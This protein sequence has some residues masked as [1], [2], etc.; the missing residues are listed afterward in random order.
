MKNSVLPKRAPRKGA[1]GCVCAMLAVCSARADWIATG[2]FN[3]TD[4]LY[5]L[6]AFTGTLV[7][8]VREADVQ[9]YDTTT[10]A[11]LASGATDSSGSFSIAVADAAQRNVGVRVLSSNVQVASLNFSVVDD[12]NSD[13]IY[14][15]HDATVDQAAHLPEANVNFGSMTMPEAIGAVASTDWSS[16]IFNVYDMGVLLA[17]WI[18]NADGARPTVFYTILWNPT[19]GRTGSSYNSSTNRLSLSDDDGYDDSNILHEIGHYI[20]DEYGR[21][22]NT[23]GTH[24][25]GDN[26]QDPRLAYSEGFATFV[27]SA[28]LN[29]AGRPRPDIYSDRDSFGVSGGGGFAYTFEAATVG[30]ATNE[31]AVTAALYDLIDTSATLDGNPGTDDDPIGSQQA[32]VWSVVE[33]MRVI[34]PAA[35]SL[36]DF[37]DIWFSLGLGS[38]AELATVFTAHNI[39]FAPDA[40]EPNDTPSTATPLTVGGAYQRNS[41]YR[42]GAQAAGD[43]DW[44]KFTAT[45]GTCY[46]IEVNGAGNTIFGRPDPEMWLI[47]PTLSTVLAYNDDPYDATLNT[48]ASSTAQD[49]SETVPV[50][51]WQAPSSGVHYLYVRHASQERNL[52]GR[53]GTYQIRV[54]SLA[55]P[56]PTITSVSE[57]RMLQGQSYQ[58]L[59]VG[60]NFTRGATVSTGNAGVTVSEVNWIAPTALVATLTPSAGVADGSY[61][62]SVSN[63]G[64]GS[65][66][67]TG[68][69]EVNA[70]AVPP[71]MMTELN[72]SSGLVEVKNLGT[73]S[74]TLTGWKIQSLRPST[75]TQ[76]FTFPAFSLAAG[77]T[78]VVHESAGTNTSTDLFDLTNSF[79]WPWVNGTSG[80]VSL[81]DDG[82]RNVDY[83]RVVSSPVTEHSLPQG[84]GGAWMAPQFQSPATGFTVARSETTALYRTP[85]GL[86]RAN[87]TMPAT[88]SGRTNNVDPWEDNDLARRAPLFGRVALLSGLRISARP[89]GTDS[90]WFGFIVNPGD[91]VVF[92]AAFTNSAGNLDMQ[93]YAPGEETTPLLSASST[94]DNETITLSPAQSTATGG[95]IYR[96]RVF[97]VSGAV[98]TY[99][100]S[101]GPVVTIAATDATAS[102]SNPSDTGQ[103]TITRSGSLS[104]ALVTRFAVGGS[105]TNGVDYTSIGNTLTIPASA[106]SATIPISAIADNLAEG[107]EGV[108]LT[109]VADPAYSIGAASNATVNIADKPIDAWR[110][111]NFGGNPA[112]SGDEADADGDGSLNLL[113]YGLGMNPN[114]PGV[115]GLP[116]LGTETELGT[117]YLTLTYLK[118]TSKSDIVYQVQSS[119]ALPGWTNLGDVL[120]GSTNGI[121]TRKARVAIGSTPKFMRLKIS[122]P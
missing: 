83:L 75:T 3:Y 31:Q 28:V 79:N 30:G 33:Q 109:L 11:V 67:S 88:A 121:E 86:S 46:A 85:F 119:V 58:V 13:A 55:T 15:Y 68:A 19:N 102:E 117:S 94:S 65:A 20:E 110:F 60:T 42:T 72:L 61:S 114:V 24:F 12:K 5:D 95:G 49:M 103:F 99:T 2:Q 34:S 100:L 37:W 22:R 116:V 16:Q 62:L 39:D 6:S 97:G 66:T 48:Q 113:E 59:V 92:N 106:A 93:L 63:P 17:D 23:G 112:N 43:E 82:G 32:A 27:S 38:A 98:N 52:L 107:T 111:A 47:D 73:V 36:E 45:A 10:L 44:F 122:R 115:A 29:Y 64:G 8:P 87:P 96:L 90:D 78:V 51:L 7:R 89:S 77:A 40:Q 81:L 9:I 4:R 76:T 14:S 50:I 105:A 70:A 101:A 84:T 18:A 57:Q 41:F 118:D 54:R 25:I 120:V 104:A 91:E 53:Y 1:L 80:D 108:T 69:F 35:T 21:S 74:A 56:T 71:V 26:D